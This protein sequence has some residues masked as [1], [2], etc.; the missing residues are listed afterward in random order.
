MS[1]R[2]PAIAL[3]D[4]SFESMG[5]M[6]DDEHPFQL[7]SK[8]ATSDFRNN[9]QSFINKQRVAPIG[10]SKKA[11]RETSMTKI[12]ILKRKESSGKVKHQSRSRVQPNVPKTNFL[13]QLDEVRDRISFITPQVQVRRSEGIDEGFKGCSTKNEGTARAQRSLFG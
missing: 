10:A 11:E 2:H 4:S 12:Q 13:D 5:Q 7:Q 3:S 8:Q 6:Q 9:I 1:P